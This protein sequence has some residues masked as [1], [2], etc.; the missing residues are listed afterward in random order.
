MHTDAHGIAI[1]TDT[2]EN[3]QESSLQRPEIARLAGSAMQ[4]SD[5]YGM[6]GTGP[7]HDP[8]TSIERV[9]KVS[10]NQ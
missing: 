3:A 2:A 5:W 8:G 6:H 9:P 1:H 4:H 7:R 10:R